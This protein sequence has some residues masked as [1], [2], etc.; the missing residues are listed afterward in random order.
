MRNLKNV[1]A[2]GEDELAA[3]MMDPC[4]TSAATVAAFSQPVDGPVDAQAAYDA[5][6]A[7]MEEVRRGELATAEVTLAGQAAALNAIF[8]A[9]AMRAQAQLD[10]PGNGAERY[11]R[12]ALKAQSQCRVTLD[13]LA[14][15]VTGPLTYRR[16]PGVIVQQQTNI[17]HGPMQ[18]NNALPDG[19]A[20]AENR[21]NVRFELKDWGNG[22]RL[23]GG[24]A[25]WS[26]A[27]YPP[28]E[29]VGAFDRAT[30]G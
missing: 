21:E 27:A 1:P 8:A 18:V 17:A 16:E 4:V 26:G 15:M 19:T 5:M 10:R 6:R 2:V 25:G 28:A 3:Q 7:R 30:D 23:D 22:E 14:G 13:A 29:A 20:A 12:M 24:A 9:M 11:L